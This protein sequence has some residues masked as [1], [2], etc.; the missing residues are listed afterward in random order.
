MSGR[1]DADVVCCVC[2]GVNT[3]ICEGSLSL[4]LCGCPRR[5]ADIRC[6]KTKTQFCL[7]GEAQQSSKQ[8]PALRSANCR[9]T[10]G[11]R[12]CAAAAGIRAS[13]HVGAGGGEST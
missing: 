11:R 12:G 1:S 13:A 6:R 4:N 9:T 8:P 7:C 2:R 3:V 5:R 10:A